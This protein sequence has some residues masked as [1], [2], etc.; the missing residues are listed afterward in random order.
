MNKEPHQ[1]DSPFTILLVDDD[2]DV[3]GANA[4]FLR[5]NKIEVLI[6]ESAESAIAKLKVER[7]DVVVTDL[8]MPETNG[9]EF[10]AKARVIRP[11]VPVVFFSG[12]ATVADVVAAMRL[13]AVDFLEKPVDPELLLSTLQALENRYDGSID[14]RALHVDVSSNSAPFRYRVLAYEKLLIEESLMK[15]D[16]HVGKVIDT[17]KINRRTLN[18]KMRRLGI[19]RQTHD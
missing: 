12:F 19:T 14:T 2:L 4:R 5:L 7:I 8:R 3:L 10:T 6:A 13:G 16:G 18:D 17:L 15:H 1:D 11:L 9:L